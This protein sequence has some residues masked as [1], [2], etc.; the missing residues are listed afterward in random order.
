MLRTR[1]LDKNLIWLYISRFRETRGETF[2][3]ATRPLGVVV[4]DASEN[5]AQK[6]LQLPPATK[7]FQIQ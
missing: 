6:K 4:P 7:N 2:L 3:T 5:F 1:L